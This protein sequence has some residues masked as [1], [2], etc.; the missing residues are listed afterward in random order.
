MEVEFRQNQSKYEKEESKKK[1]LKSK[2]KRKRKTRK[3]APAAADRWRRHKRRVIAFVFLR[4]VAN[5]KITS[6]KKTQKI[7]TN[8]QNGRQ[9]EEV[10]PF[11]AVDDSISNGHLL[12]WVVK[13]ISLETQ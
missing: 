1:N 5:R 4:P 11:V 12:R 8:K 9:P 2:K 13:K 10:R 7:E 3:A 6:E